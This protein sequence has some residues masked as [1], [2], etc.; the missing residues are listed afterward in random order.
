MARLVLKKEIIREVGEAGAEEGDN[1]RS[2]RGWCRKR[3]EEQRLVR[4]VLK[5]EKIR[6]AREVVLKKEILREAR[7]VVPKDGEVGAKEG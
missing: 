7:D 6:K 1:N 4:L 3:R 5:K 2:W